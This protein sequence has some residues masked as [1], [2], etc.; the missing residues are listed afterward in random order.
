MGAPKN[1]SRILHGHN[2]MLT[3]SQIAAAIKNDTPLKLSAANSIALLQDKQSYPTSDLLTQAAILRERYFAK[4][5]Q[6]HIINNVRNGHCQE[7]CNYCAQRKTG[8]AA[9]RSEASDIA[10]YADKS[11]AEIL[12]EAEQAYHSGAYR[13]CLVSA[14]RGLSNKKAIQ[15]YARLIQQ[16]KQCYPLQVCL[17]AG[18]LHDAQAAHTL[19][20][21]GL[22]RYNHNLNTSD[23]YY[24]RICSTHT[25]QDRLRTLTILQRAGVALCSGII[26]GMGESVADIVAV[27][28]ELRRQAVASIP[29]N[30]FLPVPGHAVA[31]K[32]Y[33]NSQLDSDA[34]LRI[35]CLLRLL[36]PQAEIRLAAGR[37]HYLTTPQ[38]QAQALSVANSLFLGGYLNVQTASVAADIAML[39]AAGYTIE[40]QAPTIVTQTPAAVP[41]ITQSSNIIKL[42]TESELRP[43]Q[44]KN[45]TARV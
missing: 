25:Y 4:R 28:L 11:D 39:K 24:Q 5:V 22:D 9:S 20:E 41:T 36:H 45:T 26:A 23:A 32:A 33:Q 18:L 21:A 37:E 34:C 42:K 6:I 30:F 10:N 31:T 12:A 2:R 16:I 3:L 29:V 38:M 7:D 17:S 19:A 8:A 43:F 35:L 44:T 13:Y 40:S 14:G 15:R 1:A 27:A